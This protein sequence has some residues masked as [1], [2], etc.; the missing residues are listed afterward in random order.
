MSK[1]AG[2]VSIAFA[3]S[4]TSNVK[5]SVLIIGPFSPVE[6]RAHLG[7]ISS[8]TALNYR[9]DNAYQCRSLFLGN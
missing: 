7:T 1:F 9:K 5:K 4:L 8:L 2:H 3:V 6:N